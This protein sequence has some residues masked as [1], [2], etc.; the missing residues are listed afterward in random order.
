[1]AFISDILTKIKNTQKGRDMRQAIYDGIEQC[2]KDA[3]GN[4]ESVAALATE[5]DA[6]RKRVDE[7]IQNLP[8]TAGTYEQSKMVLH[9]YGNDAAECGTTSGNY[10]TVKA[11]TTVVDGELSSLY[12]KKN[13][14]QIVLNKNGLYFF[15]L[16]IGV[17]SLTANKRVEL[18]PFVNGTRNAALSSS[19][20]TAGNF[21]L[22]KIV[23]VPM[24]LNA[25]DTVDFRISPVET[26]NC[27][28]QILDALIY[29]LDWEGKFQV[30]DYSTF[31]AEVRELRVGAD[32][33]IYSTA[34]QATRE[35]IK[36]LEESKLEVDK[37]LETEGKAADAK[38][39][40]E[41]ISNLKEDLGNLS[42][43]A[44][45]YPFWHE[46]ETEVGKGIQYSNGKCNFVEDLESKIVYIPA[47][48]IKKHKCPILLWGN[49]LTISSAKRVMFLNSNKE[50]IN[51]GTYFNTLS[52][53]SLNRYI[54]NYPSLTYIAVPF[55]ANETPMF[56]A[57]SEYPIEKRIKS[58]VILD[59]SDNLFRQQNLGFYVDSSYIVSSDVGM[60]S[61][62]FSSSFGDSIY[63]NVAELTKN[64]VYIFLM[65]KE[66]NK[67]GIT[68]FT[69]G[70]TVANNNVSYACF[71]ISNQTSTLGDVYIYINNNKES[72]K[73]SESIKKNL[74]DM[75]FV[76]NWYSKKWCSYG[77][78]V[79]ECTGNTKGW[80]NWV[81]DYFHFSKHYQRG[82]GGSEISYISDNEAN[83]MT[84]NGNT[85][86]RYGC[87]WDRI[88]N[89][90]PKDSDLIFV[91]F[92][93]NDIT[94]STNN[95]D[96]P[97]WSV[98]NTLDTSWINYCKEQNMDNVGDFNITS[99]KG[100]ICSTIIKIQEW[101]PN[102][103]IVFGTP[104]SGKGDDAGINYTE[105]WKNNNGHTLRDYADACI[106]AC[107]YMSV[108]VIDVNGLTGANVFNRSRYIKDQVHPT[109]TDGRMMIARTVIGGLKAIEPML[110]PEAY[111]E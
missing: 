49:S 80:Q 110:N 38:A 34:G 46:F 8:G 33:T 109:N 98:E 27:R 30:P 16:R 36:K 24:L 85:F 72:Y 111:E 94:R 26:V 20:N 92:G 57:I 63:S 102:A 93:T 97:I 87:M 41:A 70:Y 18:Y 40:G 71:V 3:T 101:C 75:F 5:V 77:D 81:T 37:N 69:S 28:L 76:N 7:L 39:T 88:V 60:V 58:D 106:S 42:K 23:T 2:Y 67:L 104:L 55:P 50:S 6:Q 22:I 90:I 11:F 15:T 53:F 95:L 10:T 78:S 108:P 21:T 103:I 4:P 25:N 105:Q 44:F 61:N 12:T 84:Y 14:S 86:F 48:C 17:N 66:L 51:N 96:D 43:D 99:Y 83:T 89:T 52:I 68:K 91:M 74:K 62:I 1:M 31:V 47:L 65:D 107:Q 82:K 32:G 19:H 59:W 9:S 35:Q 64:T 56:S 45:E 54:N 79:T 13:D 29:A 73:P 100:A